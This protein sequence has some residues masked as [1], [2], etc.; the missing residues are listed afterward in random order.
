MASDIAIEIVK[1]AQRLHN[2]EMAEK[3]TNEHKRRKKQI[4]KN[5]FAI[6]INFL[7]EDDTINE[8]DTDDEDDDRDNIDYVDYAFYKFTIVDDEIYYVLKQEKS[9]YRLINTSKHPEILKRLEKDEVI[10]NTSTKIKFQNRLKWVLFIRFPETLLLGNGSERT[11]Y[12]T[13]SMS[14]FFDA[15]TSVNKMLTDAIDVVK[16]CEII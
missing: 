2:M 9:N 1:E 5:M 4:E 14:L 11:C 10:L 16:T 8:S 3:D 13:S 15:D 6:D 12:S 7:V